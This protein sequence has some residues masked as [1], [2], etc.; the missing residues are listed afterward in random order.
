MLYNCWKRWGER[1]VFL[2]MTEGLAVGNVESKTVM[3]D[4]AYLEA[5]RTASS[6][7]VRKGI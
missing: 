1:G 4:A 6:L 7:R 5:Y 3:I 2:R